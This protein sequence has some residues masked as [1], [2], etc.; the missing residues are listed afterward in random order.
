VN[1][2]G[3]PPPVSKIWSVPPVT[4]GSPAGRSNEPTF[5]FAIIFTS[6]AVSTM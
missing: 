3:D 5:G 6:V 4:R 1:I 2:D